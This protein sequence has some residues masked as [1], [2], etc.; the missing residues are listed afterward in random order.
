MLEHEIVIK[1]G[2]FDHMKKLREQGQIFMNTLSSFRKQEAGAERYDPD[3][4]ILERYNIKGA[5]LL[6]KDKQSGKEIEVAQI[7]SGIGRVTGVEIDNLNVYCLFYIA[8]PFNEKVKVKDLIE[9]VLLSAFGDTAVIVVDPPEFL[10]RIKN[11][12]KEQG[13]VH[14]R[15]KVEYIDLEGYHG[16]VGPFVK[17][18]SYQ[19]QNELRIAIH[20]DTPP[21][22]EFTFEIGSIEDISVLLPTKEL[23]D[24][25]LHSVESLPNV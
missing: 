4:G 24:L 9:P 3:D 7:T 18:L 6:R 14:F 11:K 1:F 15:K 25:Y 5:R 21:A 2:Q 20:R 13:H 12:A 19:H 22:P 23:G 17:G 8:I 16:K 10:T